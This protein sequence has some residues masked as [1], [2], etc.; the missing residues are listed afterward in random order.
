MWSLAIFLPG[1]DAPESE[2]KM[3][4]ITNTPNTPNNEEQEA[5]EILFEAVATV[6][7]EGV[8]I[9]DS[10]SVQEIS[11]FS[12]EQTL[13]S[14]D[15]DEVLEQVKVILAL[16]NPRMISKKPDSSS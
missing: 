3:T 12:T 14:D 10:T 13:L 6:Q 16:P 9:F 4:E 8:T 15:G 1:R 11:V 2:I 7:P 5:R